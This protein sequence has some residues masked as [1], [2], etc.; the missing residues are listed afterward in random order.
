MNIL[1]SPY[2]VAIAE[3]VKEP[4]EEVGLWVTV[5]SNGFHCPI[6]VDEHVGEWARC[7]SGCLVVDID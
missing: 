5:G 3:L 2:I 1:K 4:F 7:D 6:G